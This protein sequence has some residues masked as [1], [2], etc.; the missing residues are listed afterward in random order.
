MMEVKQNQYRE[1]IDGC[2]YDDYSDA[3]DQAQASSI[4][5]LF[6]SLRDEKDKGPIYLAG[7][8]EDDELAKRKEILTN[9]EIVKTALTKP[10]KLI[11]VYNL[12]K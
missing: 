12:A 7:M 2:V 3:V 8:N 10:A 4:N 9:L 1:R 5:S 6:Y 11:S